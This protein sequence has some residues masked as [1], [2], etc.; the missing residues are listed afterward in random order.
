M[1][2]LYGAPG[3]EH[4]R[5]MQRRVLLPL[6][7]LVTSLVAIAAWAA[8][9]PVPSTKAPIKPTPTLA[10]PLILK[11]PAGALPLK[12]AKIAPVAARTLAPD[13]NANDPFFWRTNVHDGKCVAGEECVL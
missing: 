12:T 2:A 3:S 4:L 7:A 11:I 8:P 6:V 1:R 5:G 10:P 9:T 13:E